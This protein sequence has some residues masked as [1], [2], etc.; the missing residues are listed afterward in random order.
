M[1]DTV[2]EIVVQLRAMADMGMVVLYAAALEMIRTAA[3]GRLPG[4]RTRDRFSQIIKV[5]IA[6]DVVEGETYR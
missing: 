5:L 1:S 2:E 6:L 3:R 4:W